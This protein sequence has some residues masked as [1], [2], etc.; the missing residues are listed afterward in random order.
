[1]SQIR[2][3]SKDITK[4]RNALPVIQLNAQQVPG[5]CMSKDR[6]K[7]TENVIEQVERI[8]KLLPDV[9]FE[10]LGKEIKPK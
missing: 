9:K 5:N 8:D 6:R 3:D 2:M 4:I 10:A 7:M 1:M